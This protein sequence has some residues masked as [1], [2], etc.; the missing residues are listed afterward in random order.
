MASEGPKYP[1]SKKNSSK[2]AFP[3]QSYGHL[4]FLQF[5]P[6]KTPANCS[7]G[8]DKSANYGGTAQIW[9]SAKNPA[10]QTIMV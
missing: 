1:K 4:K 9:R 7:G 10:K 8:P 2:T 3:S 5:A 6:R